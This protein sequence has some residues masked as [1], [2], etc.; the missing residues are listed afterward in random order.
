[1]RSRKGLHY[2][3][4]AGCTFSHLHCDFLSTP[5][6]ENCNNADAELSAPSL[7]K[8]IRLATMLRGKIPPAS[9]RIR[10][11]PSTSQ[12]QTVLWCSK[13]NL[14]KILSPLNWLFKRTT[15]NVLDLQATMILRYKILTCQYKRSCVYCGLRLSWFLFLPY[16]SFSLKLLGF[17]KEAS[18]L[19]NCGTFD[20]TRQSALIRMENPRTLHLSANSLFSPLQER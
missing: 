1:M 14:T 6:Q 13:G 5:E 11:S 8:V 20:H 16:F 4:A 15:S 7:M 17:P 12:L 18:V 3:Q 2:R 10:K 9:L 19:L